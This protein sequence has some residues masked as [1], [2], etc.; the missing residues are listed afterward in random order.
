VPSPA[1]ASNFTV[2]AAS[3][4]SQISSAYADKQH[5]LFS[6]YLMKG[7]QGAADNNQDKKLT[8]QELNDYVA[9]NVSATALI[10]GREQNPTLQSGDPQRVLLQW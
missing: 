6:Y 7:M 3:G 5:G 8:L 10:L 4:G 2:F 1:T 9:E